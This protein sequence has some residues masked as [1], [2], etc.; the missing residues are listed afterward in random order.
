[1]SLNEYYLIGTIFI[2]VACVILIW[3]HRI[4]TEERKRIT[5]KKTA[6]YYEPSDKYFN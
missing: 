2:I 4:S 5:E 1:M 3:R 6:K